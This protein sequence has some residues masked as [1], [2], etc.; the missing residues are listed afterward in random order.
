MHILITTG[1]VAASLQLAMAATTES[2]AESYP[3][4]TVIR[5]PGADENGAPARTTRTRTGTYTEYN[6]QNLPSMSPEELSSYSASLTSAWGPF[7][8]TFLFMPGAYDGDWLSAASSG[9]SDG[10]KNDGMTTWEAYWPEYFT[11]P[12]N[13]NTP[14]D[15]KAY[16]TMASGPNVYHD[17]MTYP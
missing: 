3:Y 9:A 10:V 15:K 13:T 16:W 17:E 7:H 8:T 1:L 6:S 2:F 11:D 5:Q 12:G 4:T 14:G